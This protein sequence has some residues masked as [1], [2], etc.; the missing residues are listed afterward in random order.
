MINSK[1][2]KV[3]NIDDDDIEKMYQLYAN[4]YAGTSRALFL[5]DLQG[6]DHAII[7]TDDARSIQV[8]STVKT[9]ETEFDGEAIRAIFSGDTIVNHTFWGKNDLAQE[10]LRHAGQIKY[11]QPSLPL[12]WFLIVKGHRTYRYLSVFSRQ[13]YPAPGVNTPLRAKRLMDHLSAKMFGEAYDPNKGILC[14]PDSRGH[15][16]EEWADI[17]QKDLTLPEVQ[18]FLE[19]NP[20]YKNGDELVCICE[21]TEENLKPLTKRLFNFYK[22][23]LD[24]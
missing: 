8:F 4:Y 11:M 6:K 3:C 21:L 13:Y 22:P 10:W 24:E 7:L 23:P 14:F 16:Q 15:L 18:F 12:Y 9:I 20:G 2:V 19:R 17:P 5:A 1:T